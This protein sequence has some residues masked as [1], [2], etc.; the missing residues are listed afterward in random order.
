MRALRLHGIGP[1]TETIAAEGQIVT[2]GAIDSHIHFICP[3]QVD[4]ALMSGVTTTAQPCNAFNTLSR[5][6]FASPNNMRVLS[7]KN[8]GLSTPA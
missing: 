8:S 3:Q 4:D 2:P 6:C 7:L 1:G 5:L